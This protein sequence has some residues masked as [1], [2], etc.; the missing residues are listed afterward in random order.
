MAQNSNWRLHIILRRLSTKIVTLEQQEA[1][2]ILKP[3]PFSVNS[4]EQTSASHEDDALV[5]FC[6]TIKLQWIDF[7]TKL[8]IIL[9]I[10]I[11]H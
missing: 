2:P 11:R 1:C 3:A 4:S 10:L 7:N 9:A 8:L 5:S 6:L